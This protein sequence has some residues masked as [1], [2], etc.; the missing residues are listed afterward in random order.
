MDPFAALGIAAA[1]TQSIDFSAALLSPDSR[2]RRTKSGELQRA[3]ADDAARTIAEELAERIREM[4]DASSEGGTDPGASETET[5]IRAACGEGGDAARRLLHAARKL[6]GRRLCRKERV[7]VFAEALE[8]V[9]S[10]DEVERLRKGLRGW[11]ARLVVLS[12]AALR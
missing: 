9:W 12:V 5:Q 8:T 11:R 3:D 7:E 10:A 1:T 2:I 6:K 4:E